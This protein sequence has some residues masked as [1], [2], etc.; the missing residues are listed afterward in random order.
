MTEQMTATRAEAQARLER[1]APNMGRDYAQGR[2]FDRGAGRIGMYRCC[3]P[4]S[5]AGS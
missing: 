1:F 5:D 2:N 4:T 3:L